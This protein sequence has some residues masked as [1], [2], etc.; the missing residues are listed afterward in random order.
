M[1][2]L[3]D[4]QGLTSGAMATLVGDVLQPGADMDIGG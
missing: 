4:S 1:R 2:Q 3:L